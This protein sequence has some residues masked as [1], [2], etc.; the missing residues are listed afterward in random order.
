MPFLKLISVELFLH[1]CF[2]LVSVPC[3]LWALYPNRSFWL[4][5][6]NWEWGSVMER[7]AGKSWNG[8]SKSQTGEQKAHCNNP[9]WKNLG[10]LLQ[11]QHF[12]FRAW[13]V[14][15]FFFLFLFFK[16]DVRWGNNTT[17]A[18]RD[19]KICLKPTWVFGREVQQVRVWSETTVLQ[20]S[21][22]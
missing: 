1:N 4:P 3:S 8:C 2:S 15:L 9:F 22:R 6:V 12:T 20:I 16:L 19:G 21:R 10:R 7:Q 13:P 17:F 11:L 5:N 14:F 18:F